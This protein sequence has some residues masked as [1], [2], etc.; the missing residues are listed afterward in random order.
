MDLVMLV[1]KLCSWYAREREEQTQQ[2]YPSSITRAA[3]PRPI[4][5][6]PL[7]TTMV[8]LYSPSPPNALYA[9]AEDPHHL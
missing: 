7:P 4:P 3:V 1:N 8:P 9:P 6:I 2:S 5:C